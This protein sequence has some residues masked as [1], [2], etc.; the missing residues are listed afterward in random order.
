M[1]CL[2][3]CALHR[4]GK[5]KKCPKVLSSSPH[6]LQVASVINSVVAL[7]VLLGCSGLS[8]LLQLFRCICLFLLLLLSGFG[9][10]E[11]PFSKSS[12]LNN[13]CLLKR[14]FPLLVLTVAVEILTLVSFKSVFDELA[15]ARLFAC[16]FPAV[17]LCRG[18]GT[19][20]RVTLTLT[21]ALHLRTQCDLI[22][23]D[24]SDKG[25]VLL[26]TQVHRFR[27]G[28]WVIDSYYFLSAKTA[29]RK[30]TKFTCKWV[31]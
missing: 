26:R 29:A 19:H 6:A 23:C 31:S 2:L 11:R 30:T 12:L 25:A 24:S 20:N 10:V 5:E 14:H 17:S 9:Q 21:V 28:L 22:L 15:L 27:G 16:S 7:H 18:A 13:L 8:R 3:I 1:A 4:A